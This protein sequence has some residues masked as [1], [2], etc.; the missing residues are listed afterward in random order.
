VK[1]EILGD[2]IRDEDEK[3]ERNDSDRRSLKPKGD[4]TAAKLLAQRLL[5][6]TPDV[7]ATPTALSDS[8]KSM[9]A[10]LKKYKPGYSHNVLTL[11]TKV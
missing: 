2:H 9:A 11:T 10:L 4:L 5:A 6:Q 8:S 3:L 1:F 7:A